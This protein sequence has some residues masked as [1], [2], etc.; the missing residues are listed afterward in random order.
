[1]FLLHSVYH[2]LR[3]L[4][5]HA[6]CKGTYTHRMP[7]ILQNHTW[8]MYYEKFHCG[9]WIFFFFFFFWV[10]KMT[11]CCIKS[12]EIGRSCKTKD[13]MSVA[14]HSNQTWEKR[15]DLARW[16][17]ACVTALL[18]RP[19]RVKDILLKEFEWDR[20]SLMRCSLENF[21]YRIPLKR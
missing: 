17:K 20:I 9:D 13:I 18:C 15:E 2:V 12:Q 14:T 4:H 11:T 19:T 6:T 10:E 3:I 21:S 8:H 16:A 7:H 1:M 5:K